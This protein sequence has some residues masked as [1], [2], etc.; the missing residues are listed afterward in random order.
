LLKNSR[1]IF[2][3]LAALLWSGCGTSD[4]LRIAGDGVT[5]VHAQ[6]DNGQFVDI[7]SQADDSLRSATKKQDFL[8]LMGA[9]HRKLGKVQSASQLNYFVNFNTS[10]T[11][12]RLNYQTKFEGG[13]AQE[14][15]VWKIKGN[16]AV[17][18]GY[19]INSTALI[20]K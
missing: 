17:L 15:F 19:H 14:Y 1:Q 11:Q 5:R 2:I 18:A 6:I 12:I 7:Y 4:N 8:D 13:G 16:S 20:I 10:G 3:L 9:V